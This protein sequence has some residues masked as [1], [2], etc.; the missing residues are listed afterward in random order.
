MPPLDPDGRRCLV[1]IAAIPTFL[2]PFEWRVVARL[3]NA[4]EIHEIDVLDRRFREVPTADEAMWRVTV[5]YPDQ[6]S[7]AVERAARAGLARSFLAFAR[8]PAAR[9]VV[10]PGTGVAVVRWSDMRFVGGL[11]ALDR[12]ARRPF[13][14]T[15]VVRLSPDGRVLEERLGR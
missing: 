7:P 3:S 15:A 4:Y 11:F 9:W 8:Y 5:R 14:F 2:S 10:E 12:G 1:E 13:P 6:S